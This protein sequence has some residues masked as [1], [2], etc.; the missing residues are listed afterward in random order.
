MSSAKEI[1]Q[2]VV[3]NRYPKS[4]KEK[5][6]D[7]EMYHELVVKIEKLCNVVPIADP[8]IDQSSKDCSTCYYRFNDLDALP[9]R[10]CIKYSSYKPFL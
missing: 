10:N 4:K 3:D 5:I 6:S 9:C 7:F 2:W 1:A 8:P